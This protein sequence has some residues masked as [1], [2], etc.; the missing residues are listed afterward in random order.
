MKRGVVL[1]GADRQAEH[2]IYGAHPLG[3]PPGQV[4]VDGDHVHAAPGEGVEVGRKSG[5]Q[6]LALAGPHLRDLPG[7]KYHPA[8]HLH[9]EVALAEGPPRSLSD[10][11][12]GLCGQVVEVFA[13]ADACL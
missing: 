6:G 8:D 4:V 5:D 3:V 13:L 2:V 9:V 7:V 1:E 10:D 12:E 11:G